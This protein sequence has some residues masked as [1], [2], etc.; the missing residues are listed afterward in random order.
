MSDF[1]VVPVGTMEKMKRMEVRM[2][3]GFKVDEE[4]I[5]RQRGQIEQLR[6]ALELADALLRGANMDRSVVERKVSQAL[7]GDKVD[8]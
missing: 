5:D 8:G 7:E 2:E 1:E 4:I 6:E 3:E